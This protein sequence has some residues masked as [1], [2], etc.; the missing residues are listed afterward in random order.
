[1]HA[2]P[3]AA[4]WS[5]HNDLI[6]AGQTAFL[7]PESA[8][9]PLSSARRGLILKINPTDGEVVWTTIVPGGRGI[10]YRALAE[11]PEGNLFAGGNL[12]PIMTD[13]HGTK[14]VSRFSPDGLLEDS[15]TFG[16]VPRLAELLGESGND[17]LLTPIPHESRRFWDEIRDMTWTDDA[18]WVVGQKGLGQESRRLS[19]G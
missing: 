16:R 3:Q 17:G 7:P 12:S 4:L 5:S 14:I 6:V 15:V 1:M 8:V 9:P 11:D 2:I 10:E 13:P 18:L 19:P